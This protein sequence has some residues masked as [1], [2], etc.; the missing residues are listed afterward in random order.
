MPA[1]GVAPTQQRRSPFLL[2]ISLIYN[3]DFF[4]FLFFFF[5]FDVFTLYPPLK[6]FVVLVWLG[7]ALKGGV[8]G[9]LMPEKRPTRR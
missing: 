3:S 6:N 2:F 7:Y 4:F 8:L 9:V 5:Y 1:W